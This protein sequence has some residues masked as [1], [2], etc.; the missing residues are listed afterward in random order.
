MFQKIR[1]KTKNVRIA[2]LM[3]RII[4]YNF[5][6]DLNFIIWCFQVLLMMFSPNKHFW[7]FS[8]KQK[9]DKK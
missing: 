6:D 1:Q 3:L 4:F 2:K 7:S 9:L 5:L 8:N